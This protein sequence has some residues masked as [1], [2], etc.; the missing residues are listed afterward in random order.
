MS[1]VLRM[2][3]SFLGAPAGI[4][5]VLPISWSNSLAERPL[6]PSQLQAGLHQLEAE[7]LVSM[8]K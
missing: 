5:L 8:E 6:P 3:S 2:C 4:L 7:W 1:V